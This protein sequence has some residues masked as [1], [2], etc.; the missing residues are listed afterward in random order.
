MTF[1]MDPT[2][3]ANV[4]ASALV[5]LLAARFVVTYHRM[6]PWRGS[7]TGRHMMAFTA[8]IGALS[9][10]GALIVFTPPD[11]PVAVVL[12]VAR[13][14]LLL[15]VAGLLRQRR[16]MVVQAQHGERFTDPGEVPHESPPQ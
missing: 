2:Q 10:Y 9:L 8:T 6:A 14:V 15:M 4:A 12:R 11:G 13:V 7:T 5:F 16:H 1:P 3:W